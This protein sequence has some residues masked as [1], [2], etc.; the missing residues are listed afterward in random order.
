VEREWLIHCLKQRDGLRRD[1]G[2]VL[3]SNN[4]NMVR[5]QNVRGPSLEVGE[6]AEADENLLKLKR[7]SKWPT[8]IRNSKSAQSEAIV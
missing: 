5:I 3:I 6:V 7:L 1:K 2:L 8:R 4:S